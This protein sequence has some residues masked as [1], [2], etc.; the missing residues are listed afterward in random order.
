MQVLTST[1]RQ[2]K[3]VKDLSDEDLILVAPGH[4][5]QY[6]E[7][8]IVTSSEFDNR[9]YS[10]DRNKEYDLSKLPY[11]LGLYLGDGYVS[12]S[13][14][15][16]PNGIHVVSHKEKLGRLL[17]ELEAQNIKYTIRNY[18]DKDKKEKTMFLSL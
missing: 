5:K 14:S 11:F 13:K 10:V 17:S 1:G 8:L 15:K 16:L 9:N 12:L 4:M 18:Y 3:Y 6:S 2:W 7:P